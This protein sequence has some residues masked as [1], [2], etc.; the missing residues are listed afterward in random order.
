MNQFGARCLFWDAGLLSPPLP[1][2]PTQQERARPLLPKRLCRCAELLSAGGQ[3]TYPAYPGCPL[4]PVCVSV[5]RWVAGSLV[6]LDRG[7]HPILRVPYSSFKLNLEQPISTRTSL[8]WLG[9]ACSKWKVCAGKSWAD[10]HPPPSTFLSSHKLHPAPLLLS[11][12]PPPQLS[13]V[14]VQEHW[15]GSSSVRCSRRRGSKE[16][17]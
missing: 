16:V 12:S 7:L 17:I 8:A 1:P 5:S 3:H 6:S 9:F 14:Q 10:S 4:P 2:I 13:E 15:K 11:D